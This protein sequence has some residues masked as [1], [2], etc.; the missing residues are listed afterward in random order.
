[1]KIIKWIKIAYYWLQMRMARSAFEYNR[2]YYG[3]SIYSSDDHFMRTVEAMDDMNKYYM[4]YCKARKT[5]ANVVC[6]RCLDFDNE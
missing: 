4:K 2:T 3:D 5:K 1:M 6:S